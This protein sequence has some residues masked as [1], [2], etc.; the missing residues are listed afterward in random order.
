MQFMFIILIIF[1]LTDSSLSLF[2]SA[3]SKLRNICLKNVYLPKDEKVLSKEDILSN[4]KKL[5]IVSSVELVRFSA[6]FQPIA[7]QLIGKSKGDSDCEAIFLNA[8]NYFVD[9]AVANNKQFLPENYQYFGTTNVE[10]LQLLLKNNPFIA[11]ALTSTSAGVFS[12]KIKDPKTWYS[13]YVGTLDKSYPRLDA[14]FNSNL[15]LT[16]FQYL[17][18]ETNTPIATPNKSA[19][20]AAGDLLYL[21]FFH[22]E[23]VHSIIHIFHHMNA[24]GMWAATRKFPELT[25]W[26][27]PYI[28][29]IGL[30]Y[31]EVDLLLL[32][33]ENKG[34]LTG[35]LWRTDGDKLKAIQ[36][37]MLCKWGACKTAEQFTDEF[38]FCGLAK[39]AA[40]EAGIAPE[41][42][43]H[44]DL[45]SPFA[46][47]LTN[48][49]SRSNPQ[50]Y[51]NANRALDIFLSQC[52]DG[53][54]AISD[55]PNWVELMT[56]TGL[57]HGSTLSFTRLGV[58]PAVVKRMNP[59]ENKY[60]KVNIGLMNTAA[61]T[62]VGMIEDRH[63]FTSSLYTQTADLAVGR[64]PQ[65]FGDLLL[66]ILSPFQLIDVAKTIFKLGTQTYRPLDALVKDVL[67][68]YDA[69][70]AQLKKDL[71]D[72]VSKDPKF[73]TQGW[74]L[75]DHFPDGIDGKQLTITTYI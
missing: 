19:E 48:A 20:E 56:V 62:L 68:R 69:K 8:Q 75:S 18:S 27:D 36:R 16:S 40:R 15:E 51:A 12:L 64:L 25:L 37:E 2:N 38:I 29:N 59:T 63:I 54:S 52:G 30:K 43:K 23:C 21:L 58:A 17:D 50:K 47:D 65:N 49:F 34:A 31:V 5:T 1:V 6:G 11:S 41:Y 35:G 53:V 46:K 24:N 61:Q 22:A 33:P 57:L 3:I 32:A 28:T 44:M 67:L 66:L 42:F 4:A 39:G 73:A 26:A 55:I 13:R 14:V 74:V 72:R 9:F 60:T 70:S 7:N 45:I 71:F 10:N